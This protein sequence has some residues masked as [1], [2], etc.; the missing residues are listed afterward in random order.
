MWLFD[1]SALVYM[2]LLP[3]A[4]IKSQPQTARPWINHLMHIAHN[5][6]ST[7]LIEK[8]PKSKGRQVV[9]FVWK[10][11]CFYKVQ[12]WYNKC[13]WEGNNHRI[14]KVS[15]ITSLKYIQFCLRWRFNQI[16]SGVVI[17]PE[18]F[19]RKYVANS[20]RSTLLRKIGSQHKCYLTNPKFMTAHSI[21]YHG[22]GHLNHLLYV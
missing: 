3:L 10:Q 22:N 1:V 19:L 6:E 12:V 20:N 14:C 17:H 11:S 13:C 8:A 9:L 16:H 5:F 7:F 18:D 2:W 21:S 15:V 4:V